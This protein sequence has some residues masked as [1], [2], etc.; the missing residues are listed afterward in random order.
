[1]IIMMG[2]CRSP[3]SILVSSFSGISSLEHTN[4]IKL[5]HQLVHCNHRCHC[6]NFNFYFVILQLLSLPQFR[7]REQWHCKTPPFLFLYCK[8]APFLNSLQN[9]TFLQNVRCKTPPFLNLVVF[10]GTKTK[11]TQKAMANRR[12]WLTGSLMS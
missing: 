11:H 12:L 2:T 7:A 3:Q 10:G 8:T 4:N 5:I 9:T 6:C 1:M